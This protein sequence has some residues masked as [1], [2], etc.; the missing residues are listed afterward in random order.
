M[1]LMNDVILWILGELYCDKQPRVLFDAKK[2]RI[3]CFPHVTNICCQRMITCLNCS[4]RTIGAAGS[5]SGNRNDNK[6]SAGSD[7]GDNTDDDNNTDNDNN[8]NDTDNDNDM[9]SPATHSSGLLGKVHALVRGIRASGQ[10]Q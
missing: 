4:A 10:R 7:S 5:D 3:L 6:S 9:E 8:D 2:C 1:A